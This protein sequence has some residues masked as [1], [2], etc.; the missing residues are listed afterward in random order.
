[1]ESLSNTSENRCLKLKKRGVCCEY[2]Y[3]SHQQ[4]Y[5]KSATVPNPRQKA[6]GKACRLDRKETKEEEGKI[7]GKARE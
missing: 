3:R 6:A 1:M 2:R 4:I 7:G 5:S